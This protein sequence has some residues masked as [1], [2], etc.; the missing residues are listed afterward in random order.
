M[1]LMA[2]LLNRASTAGKFTTVRNAAV[3]AAARFS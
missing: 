2:R 1:V 3:S